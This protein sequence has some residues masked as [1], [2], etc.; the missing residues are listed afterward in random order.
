MF[1]DMVKDWAM[2]LF[3]IHLAAFVA[4]VL[5]CTAVNL[6]LTPGTLWFP[7]VAL[8][9]GAALATHAFALFL[10]KTRRRERIFIDRK[11]RS[12]AVH[13]FA[14]VATVLIL[15]YV[16]LTVTPKVWWFYWVALGWGAG[17]AFHGW[18]TFF[19]RRRKLPVPARASQPAAKPAPRKP[20]RKKPK[21]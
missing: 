2:R 10:R 15:L 3:L 5:I 13:L 9:W 19:K 17:V 8:G 12:F 20:R 21:S 7:W 1:K 11:A 18:C 6:W 16:N 14:Y 4:G